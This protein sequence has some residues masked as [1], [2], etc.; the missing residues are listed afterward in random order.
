MHDSDSYIV[1]SESGLLDAWL[2]PFVGGSGLDSPADLVSLG[3]VNLV[4]LSLASGR[5]A[6][7]AQAWYSLSKYDQIDMWG[8]STIHD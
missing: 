4:L 6:S 5:W 1:R 2:C 8:E 7:H 3:L